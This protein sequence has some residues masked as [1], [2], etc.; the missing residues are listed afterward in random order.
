MVNLDVFISIPR[1]NQP[2]NVHNSHS[3]IIQHNRLLV[4]LQS[5]TKN[6]DKIKF[7]Y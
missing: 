6:D 7:Y 2:G 4:S 3:D 1:E 5:Q